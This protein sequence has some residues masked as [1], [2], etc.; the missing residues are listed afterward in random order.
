MRVVIRVPKNAPNT[1]TSYS[2]FIFEE[3]FSDKLDSTKPKLL[4]QSQNK[5]LSQQR[6]R[7]KSN[8]DKNEK[9]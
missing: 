2:N 9:R 1:S 4:S 8:K 5:L 7:Q 3:I 6:Q